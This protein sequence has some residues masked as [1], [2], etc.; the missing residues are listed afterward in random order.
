[1]C[2]HIPLLCDKG[3]AEDQMNPSFIK[4]DR[5]TGKTKHRIPFINA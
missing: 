2:E 3:D 5:N 4:Y 1:M